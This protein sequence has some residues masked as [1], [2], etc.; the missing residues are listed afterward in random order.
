MALISPVVKRNCVLQ[1]YNGTAF[2]NHGCASVILNGN[3]NPPSAWH[4]GGVWEREIP[5][6]RSVLN[7]LLNEQR[8]KLSDKRLNILMCEVEN[9]LNNR[10]LT[11]L[12]DDP[13]DLEPLTPKSPAGRYRRHLPSRLVQRG[14]SVRKAPGPVPGRFILDMME[15]GIFAPSIRKA[16]M[17]K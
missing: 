14:R 11:A 6:I 8:L 7:T 13:K 16:K 12:S 2:R 5:T 9:I 4:F 1:S 17:D 10:P 3:F 15:E